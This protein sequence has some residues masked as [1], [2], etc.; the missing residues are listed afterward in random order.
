MYRRWWR[1][2][3]AG[4]TKSCWRSST[5]LRSTSTTTSPR[6]L[7]ASGPSR[8]PLYDR[9]VALGG[10]MVDFGGWELPQQYTSIRNEH[11]AV[12]R[13][14]GLFDVAHMGR[15]RVAGTSGEQFLQGLVTNDLAPLVH[16]QA[17]YNLM[18]NE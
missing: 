13:A 9:H 1:T 8:T 5:R 3:S 6:N 10:R 7:T 2:R 17:Q 12:R 14:A 4:T 11:L 16:G 18:C 15:F